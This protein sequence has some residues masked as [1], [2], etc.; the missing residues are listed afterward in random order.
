MS[1]SIISM[2]RYKL[3]I[4]YDGM[5]FCGWQRQENAPSVQEAIEKAFFKIT[6]R[7][8]LVEGA[9]RTDKG[10]HATGQVAHVDLSKKWSPLKL[11]EALNHFLDRIVIIDVEYAP[12]SFHAR[13]TAIERIYHYRMIHRRPPLCLEKHRAWHIKESLNITLMQ[14]AANL[15][16]GFHDFSAFRSSECQA[17]NPC[18]TIHDVVLKQNQDC[19]HTVIRAPSFL[20]NQVRI[21]VGTLK[22]IGE[23]KLSLETIPLALQQK[24]RTKV[25]PTAPPYGLYLVSVLYPLNDQVFDV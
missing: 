2:P 1:N 6:G 20:H 3:T 17:R 4:E 14:E 19:I 24:D 10:V 8:T 16:K 12:D 18:R 13:F 11:R 21:M 5:S 22:K 15:F 23:E 25:G 7:Y 9:G